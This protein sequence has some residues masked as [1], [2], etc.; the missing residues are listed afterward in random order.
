VKFVNPK[1]DVAFQKIF[2]SED[3]TEVLIGFLN[4]VLDL[5]GDDAIETIQIRNP[6]Q[7]P[8]L[9]F[10]KQSILDI[11][12]TDHKGFT[13]IVEMQVAN[14]AGI[15]KRFT[16]YV[17]KEYAGQIRSGE[18]YPELSPVIFI[19]VLDFV[20]FE[21]ESEQDQKDE[22]ENGLEC[23]EIDVDSEVERKHE[24]L[25]CHKILDVESH[26]NH[27]RDMAFYF[28][29][30]PKFTKSADEDELTHVLDKWIYFIRHAEDL[31]VIP[32]HVSEPDLQTAYKMADQFGWEK[33]DL[34][35]YEYRGI[36]IQDERGALILA[37]EKGR[38]EGME[39]AALKIARNML[40]IGIPIEQIIQ[41]T[42]LSAGQIEQE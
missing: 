34:D 18:E 10:Q 22:D 20:L 38:E 28:I 21:D 27:L 15:A 29:E 30:L 26:E 25:S 4:A 35:Q 5:H 16:Y 3:R 40:S 33:E 36:K 42:G 7:T 6:Y 9:L 12:A 31:D 14:V 1:N 8:K 41:A 11:Y 32:E 23:E 2:G 19:G 13:F 17:A 24:Y 37:E 39:S